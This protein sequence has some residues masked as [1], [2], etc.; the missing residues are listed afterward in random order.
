MP[1][2]SR[3]PRSNK[4]GFRRQLRRNCISTA[5]GEKKQALYQGTAS[6]VPERDDADG[7]QPLARGQGLKPSECGLAAR[8]K[9]CPDTRRTSS[10]FR[11]SG[12]SGVRRCD[13]LRPA[14]NH[15]LTE[16]GRAH[17]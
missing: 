7:L 8:L 1:S 11:I 13:V 9:P 15:S 4:P 17:V 10:E 12:G 16:I 2:C 6:A 3:T 14:V 5:E